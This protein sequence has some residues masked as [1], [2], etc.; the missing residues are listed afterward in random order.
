MSSGGLLMLG[1]QIIYSLISSF[2]FIGAL[3][4]KIV[5]TD[6]D[7]A[8]QKMDL[9]DFVYKTEI[10]DGIIAEVAEEN[11]L[12]LSHHMHEEHHGVEDL[13]FMIL[14]RKQRVLKLKVW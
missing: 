10:T 3:H 1:K 9:F 2:L 6:N 11:I 8:H 4:A 7:V 5:T 14:S 13:S 12:K